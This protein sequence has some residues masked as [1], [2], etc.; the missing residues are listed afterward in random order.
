MRYHQGKVYDTDRQQVPTGRR[1]SSPPIVNEFLYCLHHRETDTSINWRIAFHE[2]VREAFVANFAMLS[3]TARQACIA[4]NRSIS[5]EYSASLQLNNNQTCLSTD[6][7]QLFGLVDEIKGCN[8]SQIEIRLDTLH[9][10]PMQ[11]QWTEE[12]WIVVCCSHRR[13]Q[14]CFPKAPPVIFVWRRRCRQS[15]S[16]ESKSV[17]MSYSMCRRRLEIV[18][19]SGLL[20][21]TRIKLVAPT[22]KKKKIIGTQ[23]ISFKFRNSCSSCHILGQVWPLLTGV[24]ITYRSASCLD[25]LYDHATSQRVLLHSQETVIFGYSRTIYNWRKPLSTAWNT[26]VNR[27]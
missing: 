18:K 14:S 9:S 27:C 20:I 24:S 10:T 22:D 7:L 16:S 12:N 3:E 5:I 6:R 4:F 8:Y 17:I 19:L 15:Y 23:E 26:F 11:T 25:R 13:C 21:F 2:S 1:Q